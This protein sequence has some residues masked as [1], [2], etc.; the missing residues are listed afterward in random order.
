MSTARKHLVI[1]ITGESQSDLETALEEVQRKV[2][3]GYLAG[4][5]GNETNSYDFD[6]NDELHQPLIPFPG[7][8]LIPFPG[9]RSSDSNV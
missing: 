8:A 1:R 2:A 9:Y 5:D 7:C 3:D 4:F 6:V